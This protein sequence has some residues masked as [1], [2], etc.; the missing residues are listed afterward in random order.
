MPSKKAV[1]KHLSALSANSGVLMAGPLVKKGKRSYV[2]TP[3]QCILTSDCLAYSSG[4]IRHVPLLNMQVSVMRESF[5]L[6]D[7]SDESFT[8][9]CPG[10]SSAERHKEVQKWT[11]EIS[12]ARDLTR[13]V[14]NAVLKRGRGRDTVLVRTWLTEGAVI[15]AEPYKPGAT[16][17]L[18]RE[19]TEILPVPLEPA[20]VMHTESG[21]SLRLTFS[22]EKHQREWLHMLKEYIRLAK[23]RPLPN[24][25]AF[26]LHNQVMH[27]LRESIIKMYN[28]FAPQKVRGVVRCP[29]KHAI[30]NN[31]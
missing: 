10:K 16:M 23:A 14:A 3:R 19:V 26:K 21:R 11:Q 22:T 17:L 7:C 6:V 2:A 28:K 18:L 12:L 13:L 4:D 27:D 1:S 30:E 5:T 8:F 29:R 24:D 25:S 20:L 15:T 31:W 9:H